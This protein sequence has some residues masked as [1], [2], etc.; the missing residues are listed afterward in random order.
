MAP[1]DG[2]WGQP[3][4]TIDWCEENYITTKYIAEFWNTI[5]NL[6]MIIPSITGFYYAYRNNLHQRFMFCFLSITFVGF[7]S[8]N[9]H[10]TLL[11]EMQLFDEIPMIWGSLMLVYCLMIHYY[12]KFRENIYKNMMLKMILIT[13]GVLSLFTYLYLKTP[14]LFQISYV[15]LVTYMLYLTIL[16][17][18]YRPCNRTVFYVATF[19]Y[20]FGAFLWMIDNFYCDQLRL[21]RQTNTILPFILNPMTQLHAWWHVFAGYGSYLH[22]LF[23]THSTYLA[24]DKPLEFRF[25]WYVGLVLDRCETNHQQ[26]QQFTNGKS[27]TMIKKVT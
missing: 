16:L 23:C 27:T 25:I 11:Y 21:F 12:P 10:M 22:I 18:R 3:T 26:Q 14:I 15:I 8:W 2:Y 7:G 9:F 13:Y 24:T 5:S 20:Y 1:I 6:A 4:S 19:I 17:L